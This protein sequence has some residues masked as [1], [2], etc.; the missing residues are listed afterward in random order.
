MAAAIHR[1]VE[2]ARLR[3]RAGRG[4]GRAGRLVRPAPGPGRLRRRP[5]GRLRGVSAPRPGRRAADEDRLRRPPVR[6]GHHRRGR[7]RGPAAGRA[8]GGPSRGGR[9]T[10]SPPV[11]RTSSPG[12]TSTRRARSGS[13]G[14][15]WCGSPRLPG[16]SPSFHPLSAALLAD[17]AAGHARARPNGGWTCR[18]R[19]APALAEAAAAWDGDA[20]VFYPYLYWPTVRVIDRVPRADHPPPGRP[21]R[22]GPPPADLPAGVRGGRR[23]GV[24][25]RGRAP[26]GR[27]DCSR[28][29]ATTSSCSAWAWTTPTTGDRPV[30]A[31]DGTVHRSP[32][33]DAPVPGLP[34]PGRR[35]QGDDPAGRLLR[36]LQ[37]AP[38]RP[39]PP[40]AGRAGGRGA[41]RPTRTSTWSARCPRTTSGSC[42]PGRRP[43][44]RR[45]RGRR[46]HWWWPRRGAPGPR[47][48]STPAAPPPSSTAAGRAVGCASTAT[49]SSRWR[50]TGW[51]ATRLRAGLGR[52]GR[53][54]VDARFRWPRDRPLR[55]VRRVGGGPGGAVPPD[56]QPVTPGPA[57]EPTGLGPTAGAGQLAMPGPERAG[58][59]DDDHVDARGST[60]PGAIRH[61]R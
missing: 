34:G 38:P 49:A 56:R 10:C 58:P 41:R 11:R 4:R 59:G 1:V 18:G 29:P 33:P 3:D 6:A 30:A 22:A 61:T 31:A 47:S 32:V 44:C 12:T 45:R 40:G 16:A 37:G 53:A 46:S 21:R 9:S 36:P 55:G 42:S 5:R 26:P 25:D 17:P 43:W 50:S 60:H 35:P 15:G 54:Y 7:D 20:M 2:D 13:P 14:C 57:G 24:P 19:V 39:A 23:P 48:W 27:A 28:W 52:R 51:S 8:P